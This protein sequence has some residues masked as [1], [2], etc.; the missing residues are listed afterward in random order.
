MAIP[1]TKLHANRVLEQIMDNVIGLQR[2]MRNN[3]IAH[4][5]M[6]LAQSPALATLQSFV[7]DAAAAYLVRIG[8]GES[9][10]NTPAKLTILNNTLSRI[11]LVLTDI[12]DVTDALK[13]AAL[14]IQSANKNTYAQIVTVCDAVIAGVNLPDSLWP[15]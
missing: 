6:A 12:T 5:A 9:I 4:R 14:Q 8:W 11:G 13:S 7:N 3:A 10:I 15:E 1:Q 2:D